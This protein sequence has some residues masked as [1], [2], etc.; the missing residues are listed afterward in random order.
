M[1]HSDYQKNSQN[2]F[3]LIELLIVTALMVILTLTVSA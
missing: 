2:G 1:Q 3:T